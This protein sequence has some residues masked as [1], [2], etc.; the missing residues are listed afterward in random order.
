MPVRLFRPRTL[1]PFPFRE[2]REAAR[3]IIAVKL[4]PRTPGV[5]P[6]VFRKYKTTRYVPEL[7]LV[8]PDGEAMESLDNR[9]LNPESLSRRLREAAEEVNKS[10][11]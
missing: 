2:L 1:W 3:G 9:G 4:D 5:D 7:V 8:A 6:E 11:Y 10:R